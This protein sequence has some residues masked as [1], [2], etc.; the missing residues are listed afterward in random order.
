M[1]RHCLDHVKRRF[2]VTGGQYATEVG[3]ALGGFSQQHGTAVV[4]DQLCAEDRPQAGSASLF[5]EQNRSIEAVRI[6][7][8]HRGGA[9]SMHGIDQRRNIRDASHG[10]KMRMDMEMH[11]RSSVLRYRPGAKEYGVAGISVSNGY[12]AMPLSQSRSNA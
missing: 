8:G 10:R 4:R 5:H 11:H 9:M 1:A 6:R 2:A 12:R 3:V 7:Q